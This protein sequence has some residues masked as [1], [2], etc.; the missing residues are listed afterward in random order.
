[1]NAPARSIQ[2]DCGAG[3]RADVAWP[4]GSKH[5]V[6]SSKSWT[7]A[8]ISSR[9]MLERLGKHKIGRSCLHFKRL[10]DLDRSVRE[11]PIAGSV[12]E[13]RQLYPG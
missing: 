3:P 11:A 10:A 6:C 2:H 7:T 12:A 5:W 1:M 4:S 13:M 8:S 9:L